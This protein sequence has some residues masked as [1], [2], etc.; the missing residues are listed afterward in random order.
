MNKEL[1]NPNISVVMS[2]FNGASYLHE[3]IESILNQS[4]K[5]FE[6]IIINDGSTDETLEIIKSY[7]DSRIVLISRKNKGLIDSL[8]EAISL[9]KGEY[10]A[11]MDAD[12]I[13]YPTRL[14][15]QYTFMEKNADIVVCGAWAKKF[16][17]DNGLSCTPVDDK[18]IREKFVI[19]S[20]FIHP[21]VFIRKSSLRK[22]CIK[23]DSNYIHAE[24]YKLWL[25]LLRVGKCANIPKVLLRY[26]VS[27]GQISNKYRIVQHE[28]AK[29]I[30]REFIKQYF[31]EINLD[32]PLP[33]TITIKTIK[34]IKKYNYKDDKVIN[35]IIYTMYLSLIK[36][37][38]RSFFNFLSSFDYLKS[39]YSVKKII[40]IIVKHIN[41]NRFDSYL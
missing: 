2:V 7:K 30:R 12:D 5:N 40:R 13:S 17:T 31:K 22:E 9:A 32:F 20:P 26:R 33:S 15:E 27:Q 28:S 16:G 36:Y 24:D 6:F 37:S 41:P 25:E 19:T 4:Y 34:T 11:R 29:K 3:S 39:P 1:F 10:I 8:N 38:H 14:D 21:S 23:Y 35:A 18:N